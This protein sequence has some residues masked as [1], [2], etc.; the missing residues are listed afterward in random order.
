[1]RRVFLVCGLLSALFLVG[2][3]SNNSSGFTASGNFSTASISGQYAYQ[4]SGFDLTT[5]AS[6]VRA[7]VFTADGTGRITSGTDDFSEG[8]TAVSNPISG[9][10]SVSND[11]TG[12]ATIT[13][14]G[15]T[16]TLGMTLVSPSKIYL[17]EA[18]IG[19]VGG[20][21][22]EK[23][24]TAVLSTIP[25]GTFAFRMHT[26]SPSRASS[27]T[28]GAMTISGGV[29]TGSEDVNLNAVVSSGTLS[30][31]LNVPDPTNGRGTGTLTDSLGVTST[32]VYYVVDSSNIRFFSTTPATVGLGRAELQSGAPF[33][34]SSLNGG[35]ALGIKGDTATFFDGF[36][37]VGRFSANGTGGISAGA[38]DL[39]QDGAISS[40]ISFTGTYSVTSNGRA[41]VTVNG[42]GLPAQAIIWMVSPSR[43]FVLINSA[44]P[45]A[46]GTIDLQ[47]SNSFSNSTIVGQFGF[48]MDGFDTTPNTYDRVG[49]LQWD[50]AGHLTL[51]ELINFSGTLNSAVLSGTYSVAQNGRATGSINSLSGNLVFYL[52]SGSD[53]YVLQADQ[54]FELAGMVSK[55]Q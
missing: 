10:Y 52:V 35:Y 3:G 27:G 37:A 15:A 33:S 34:N 29:I 4:F 12:T 46:E 11:G 30:G 55:Q 19:L 45:V 2:C 48:V 7:G 13:V 18:D 36:Q 54:G 40:N 25:S 9:T 51:N 50:G 1:V 26:A 49:T 28:V 14:A 44:N 23:Q 38:E 43:A 47:R 5:S 16:I 22:A 24:N 42:A 31:S 53:A 6:Y 21:V 8:T 39:A 32:F 17:I 41:T 20:G